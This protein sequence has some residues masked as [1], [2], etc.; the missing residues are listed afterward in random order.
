MVDSCRPGTPTAV[1]AVPTIS[2]CSNGGCLRNTIHLPS[3]CQSRTW[4]LV[5]HQE[6]HP[7]PDSAPVISEPVSCLATCFPETPCV[8]FVCRPIGSH[9]AG[10]ASGPR[11][12]PQSAASRQ[13]SCLES[14]S[15]H[16]MCCENSSSGQS[17]GQ[18]SACP[19]APCLTARDPPASCDDGSCQ[20][21]CSEVTSCAQTPCL[22]SSCETGSCQPTCYQG[23][24]CQPPKG[25][26]QPCQ[27]VYYQ[28]ICYVLKSCQSAPCMPVSCQPVTCMCSCGQTCCVPSPCQLLHCQPAPLISFICQPA[29]PCQFP[30]FAKSSSKSGSCV[31]ISGQSICGEPTP[32]QSGCE[33]LSCHPPCCVTGVGKP[34]SSGCCPP[35][36]PDMCQAGTCGPTS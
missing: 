2:A 7:T 5:T 35:T 16:T 27:S 14:A 21:S 8:G 34:S 18:G 13:P 4:Q 26:G 28:P 29:A 9:T 22:P 24:P 23:G 12:T 31:M 30:C 3:S 15:R 19:S 36:S 33:S 10:C 17:S 25:E 32:S 11:G 1:P 6:N 20:P